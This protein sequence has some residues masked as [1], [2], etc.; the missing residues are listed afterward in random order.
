MTSSAA[1]VYRFFQ[2]TGG[3]IPSA[4]A[5]VIVMIALACA[6]VA[7]GVLRVA[8]QHEVLRLGYELER[9]TERVA[10]LREVRRRLDLELATLTAPERIKRLATELGMTP[11]S[12][13]RIRVVPTCAS[14]F[15]DAAR[16]G[17]A[18][19]C[20]PPHRAKV[21]VQP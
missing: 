17:E 10:Q 20:A 6:G 16:S 21:A 7:L 12:P 3:G 18:R 19:P 2:R 13:D 9:E 8:R 5:T 15:G 4:R 14:P 11:V 1:P